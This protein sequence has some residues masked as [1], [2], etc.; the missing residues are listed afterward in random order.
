ML[1]GQP[2]GLSSIPQPAQESCC[3][4]LTL[5]PSQEAKHG[6]QHAH[7]GGPQKRVVKGQVQM[8]RQSPARTPVALGHLVSRSV[9]GRQF[10]EKNFIARTSSLQLRIA[11]RASDTSEVIF[12][13]CRVPEENLLGPE[14]E[15]FISSLKILE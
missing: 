11:M 4:Q 6:E 3:W 7:P 10:I 14:G 2:H 5:P 13:D 12:S 15:G 8:S 9:D 1:H